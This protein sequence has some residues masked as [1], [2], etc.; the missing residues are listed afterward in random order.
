MGGERGV[1]RP[2]TSPPASLPTHGP[3]E[4]VHDARAVREDEAESLAVRHGRVHGVDVAAAA[5]EGGGGRGR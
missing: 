5:G 4:A 1:R 2:R 3:R